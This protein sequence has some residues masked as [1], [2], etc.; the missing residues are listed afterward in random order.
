MS[1]RKF[2]LILFFIAII[3]GLTAWLIEGN[4]PAEV[5]LVPKFWVILGF[6]LV[7]TVI[8][9]VVSIAGIKNGGEN[10][11]FVIM[12]AII[13]KLLFSMGFVIVYLLKFKVNSLLFAVE[14]FSLY[15]SFTSFEVY[16]LLCN[17][18]HQNKT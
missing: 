7:I 4:N 3:L 14:F 17:L 12:G 18:R 13:I 15:F 2:I 16:A 5:I 1:L 8:A 10:S 9:Y 6:L 11:V